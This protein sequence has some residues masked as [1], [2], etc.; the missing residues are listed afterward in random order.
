M[1]QAERVFSV[2]RKGQRKLTLDLPFTEAVDMAIRECIRENI[3]KDILINHR[4]EVI[5]ML[6]TEYDEQ[7]HMASVKEEGQTEKTS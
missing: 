7:E 1:R 3:L 2:Y 5:N 4:A 6:F